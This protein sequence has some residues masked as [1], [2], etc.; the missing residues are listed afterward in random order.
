MRYELKHDKLAAQ[1]YELASV[2]AKARR[3]AENIYH[4]YEEIG[5][6]R[7]FTQEEL[8]YLS[9]FQL[10]MRPTDDLME[11]I[12]KSKKELNRVKLLE[13]Q[14]ERERLEREKELVKRVKVRQRRISWVI[15]IAGVVAS[16]L[17]IFALMENRR[18]AENQRITEEIRQ[19]LERKNMLSEGLKKELSVIITKKDPLEARTYVAALNEKFP[20]IFVDARDWTIYE[21]VELNK[22]IWMAENLKYNVGNGSWLYENDLANEERFGRLY[23]WEAAQNA[24]PSGWRIPSEK[25]WRRMAIPF[26][27]VSSD[28]IDENDATDAYEALLKGGKSNFNALLGGKRLPSGS[29]SD[30]SVYGD[31]W[32]S[33]ALDS[34]PKDAWLFSFNSETQKLVLY[35]FSKSLGGSCRCIKE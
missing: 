13:E 34:D 29:F 19:N 20:S 14:K 5:S 23:N 30:L 15:G 35:D 18:A 12:E 6:S 31:Y 33:S 3:K 28:A 21:T 17:L 16:A 8:D 4:L 2:E 9:Q 11:I 25:E 26:G 27:R 32:T 24:C 10:V 1:I 22:Q 7:L